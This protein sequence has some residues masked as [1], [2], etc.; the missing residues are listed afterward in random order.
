MAYKRTD[1]VNALLREE[2][3]Q[4]IQR[5]V[6]DPRVG[7]ST[8]TGVETSSDLRHARVFVSFLGTPE[9]GEEALAALTDARSYLRQQLA[10]RVQ[11]RYVPEL[12]F[13]RDTSIEQSARIS[14]LLREARERE[15]REE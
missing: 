14:A 5:Q 3:Q 8:V 10:A 11:L 6:H 2:L 9:E 7:F 4:L 12:S 13:K 1:R 15:R